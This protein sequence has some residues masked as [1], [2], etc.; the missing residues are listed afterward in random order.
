M[1]LFCVSHMVRHVVCDA[2]PIKISLRHGMSGRGIEINL[3]KLE[4]LDILR[5]VSSSLQHCKANIQIS[6][7]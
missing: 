5:R 4:V 2:R 3:Q 1:V 6:A 7:T